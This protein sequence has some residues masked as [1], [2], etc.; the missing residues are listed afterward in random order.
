MERTLEK[1]PYPTIRPV[2]GQPNF[3][4]VTGVHLKLKSNEA[5]AHSNGV[6]EWLGLLCLINPKI[7]NTLSTVYLEPP[8]NPGQKPTIPENSTGPHF[9]NQEGS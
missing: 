5:Y 1:F 8:N 7:Y 6:N 3:E 4:T 2:S 9:R